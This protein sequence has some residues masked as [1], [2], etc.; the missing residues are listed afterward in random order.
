[1]LVAIQT[2]I[3]GRLGLLLHS[4]IHAAL[5]SFL[6]GSMLLVCILI[7]LIL[8]QPSLLRQMQP[9]QAPWW[10]WTGGIVGANLIAGTAFLVPFFGT[11]LTVVTIL[12]GMMLGGVVSIIQFNGQFDLISN[13]NINLPS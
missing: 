5:I 12:S 6:V 1:M 10:T 9:N 3:N 2:A 4:S 8:K 11:G 13:D 7:G